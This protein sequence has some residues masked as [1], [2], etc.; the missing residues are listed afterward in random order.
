[1]TRANPEAGPPGSG[2]HPIRGSTRP[3]PALARATRVG[4]TLGYRP[5]NRWLRRRIDSVRYRRLLAFGGVA[6]GLALVGVAA[7]RPNLEAVRLGYRVEELRLAK[8]QLEQEIRRYRAEL[9]TLRDPVRLG[10]A[11]RDHFGLVEPEE[12]VRLQVLPA[13]S[14]LA[15]RSLARGGET[16]REGPQGGAR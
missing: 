13:A 14:A 3:N 12:V 4:R 9:A 16:R 11:A 10:R 15:T 6:L 7:A 5:K 1:M 8:E 2:R